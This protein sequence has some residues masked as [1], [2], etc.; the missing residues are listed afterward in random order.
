M[1]HIIFIILLGL[2]AC[3]KENLSERSDSACLGYQG[4][5]T[6]YSE[7]NLRNGKMAHVPST[8]IFREYGIFQH[9]PYYRG[10]GGTWNVTKDTFIPD[11]ELNMSTRFYLNCDTFTIDYVS[12]GKVDK[13]F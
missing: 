5:D 11:P 8:F 9:D 1:K 13:Y 10:I 2:A 4:R 7:Y 6:L 3:T 12:I